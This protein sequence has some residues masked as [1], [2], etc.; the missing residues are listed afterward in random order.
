MIIQSIVEKS[1]EVVFMILDSIFTF[2]DL[3]TIISNFLVLFDIFLDILSY[4]YYFLPMSYLYPLFGAVFLIISIRFFISL[5][6]LV[7]EFIPFF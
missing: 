3:G 7:I 5:L 1:I 6:R 4:V 2:V